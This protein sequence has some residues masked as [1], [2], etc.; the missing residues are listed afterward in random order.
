MID[1]C[2]ACGQPR[3]ESCTVCG[4]QIPVEDGKLQA[5]ETGTVHAGH[6]T[7]GSCK[8]SGKSALAPPSIVCSGTIAK[9]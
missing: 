2:R 5:H 3:R 1:L 8:G 4:Q 6:M 9:P 7:Y